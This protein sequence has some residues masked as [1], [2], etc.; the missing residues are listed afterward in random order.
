MAETDGET[1][2]GFE[3]IVFFSDAVF[4]IVITL[5]VLPLSAEFELPEEP[6]G[7]LHQLVELGPRIVSFAVTFLVIGQFWMAHR[8]IFQLIDRT[9]SGLL[10][11]NLFCLLTVSFMVFPSAVIGAY[12]L[13]ED[14]L[15]IVF[16]AGCLTL[17]SL[18][19]GLVWFYAR[20]RGLIDSAVPSQRVHQY[21]VGSLV[22]IGVFALSIGAAFIS[23]YAALIC[24]VVVMP[25]AR[26]LALRFR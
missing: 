19:T 21:T 7:L 16:Y 12:D 17:A 26:L 20:G 23:F 1:A 25:I 14:S 3:R 15:P 11:L 10:W 8:R 4:A 22:T 24:W 6:A 13:G 5:L 18:A 9:D 2:L